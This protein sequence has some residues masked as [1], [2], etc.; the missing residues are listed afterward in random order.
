VFFIYCF[1]WPMIE[2]LVNGVGWVG[3]LKLVHT[4]WMLIHFFVVVGTV[5]KSSAHNATLK[6]EVV[7]SL[8]H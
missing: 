4:K 1:L 2:N 8:L 6:I 3:T 5:C 7:L